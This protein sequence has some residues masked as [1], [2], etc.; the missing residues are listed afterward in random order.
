[1]SFS[2]IS[3]PYSVKYQCKDE[4]PPVVNYQPI[5]IDNYPVFNPLQYNVKLDLRPNLAIVNKWQPEFR[6]QS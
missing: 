4:K 2:N 1:M 3:F 5:G 6:K